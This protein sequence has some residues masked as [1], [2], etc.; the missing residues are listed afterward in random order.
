MCPRVD[1][2][3][4]SILHRLNSWSRIDVTVE[5]FQAICILNRITP[6]FLKFIVGLGRKFSSW[7]E[8]FMT[9]YDHILFSNKAETS[10]INQ[11]KKGTQDN[12]AGGEYFTLVSSLKRMTN[13]L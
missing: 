2:M 8:D 12:G 9:C 10:Q 13:G 4:G 5:M 6:Q 3:F 1:T 7:D 11:S